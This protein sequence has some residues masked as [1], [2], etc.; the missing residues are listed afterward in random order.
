MD[1]VQRIVTRTPLTELWN[2]DGLLDARRAK[3]LGE[4]DIQRLLQGGSNFVVA[5]VGQPLRWISESDRFAFWK[6]E[7]KCRLIAPDADGFHLEDYPG[8]YC[9]VAAMWECASRT[10]VIVLE[11]HH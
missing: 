4:A 7:V 9:Y 5:E 3:D 11:K 10:P 8:S 6:A 2:N 1:M